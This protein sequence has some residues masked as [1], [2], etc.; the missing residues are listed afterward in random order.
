M[1]ALGTC[2]I[3]IHNSIIIHCSKGNI[4]IS[5]FLVLN[6]TLSVF[7]SGHVLF[8]QLLGLDVCYLYTLFNIRLFWETDISS[9][10]APD[11]HFFFRIELSSRILYQKF[12]YQILLYLFIWIKINQIREKSKTNHT[13]QPPTINKKKTPFNSFIICLNVSEL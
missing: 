6:F 1:L 13:E 3:W 2:S 11:A 9:I 12:D 10:V 4:V 5:I 7:F 8:F